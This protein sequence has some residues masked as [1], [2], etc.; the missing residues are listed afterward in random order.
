M[1][2]FLLLV[3]AFY[4]VFRIIIRVVR[5]VYEAFVGEEEQPKVRQQ[6]PQQ[7]TKVEYHDVQDAKF[8]DISDQTSK[9][10]KE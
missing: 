3:I 6:P 4:L 9:E 7:H 1:L 5:T 2:R 8:K 10:S